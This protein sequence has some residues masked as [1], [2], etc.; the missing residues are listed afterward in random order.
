M[1]TQKVAF[2]VFLACCLIGSTLPLA[3]NTGPGKPA[4]GGRRV[5]VIYNGDVPFDSAIVTSFNG[6]RNL[7]TSVGAYAGTGFNFT[8]EEIAVPE[9]HNAGLT[10]ATGTSY[11]VANASLPITAS[12]Y[13]IVFDL[14]FSNRNYNN[15]SGTAGPRGTNYIRG[16]SIVQADVTAYANYLSTGGGLFILGDNYWDDS[17]MRADGFISRMENMYRLVNQ[18]ASTGVVD[19]TAFKLGAPSILA[20]PNGSNPYNVETDF[21]VLAGNSDTTLYPGPIVGTG[22]GKIWSNLTGLPT[23]GVGVVWDG[24]A[25]DLLPAYSTGRMLYWGDVSNTNAWATGGSAGMRRFMENAIDYLF[26]DNCCTPPATLCGA[27]PDVQEPTDLATVECFMDGTHPYTF[28]AGTGSWVSGGDRNGVGGY[29]RNNIG[30]FS[31]NVLF[32]LPLTAG[33]LALYNQLCFSMRHGL[34]GSI[35]VQIW[36]QSFG[37]QMTTAAAT[38]PSGAGWTDVCLT[39]N[40]FAGSATQLRFRIIYSGG[41]N[42]NY[43]L[44]AISLRHGCGSQPRVVDPACCTLA[45]P[46]FTPT[47]TRT[48]TATHTPTITPTRTPTAT[49]SYSPTQT[50]T[51]TPSAT[52]SQTPTPT[53]TPTVTP[54][55]TMTLT[56]TPSRTASA[57]PTVTP[58]RTE[59]PSH[60]PTNTMGP[61]PTYTATRTDTP[62]AT[63]T[64]TVTLTA[65][66]TVTRTATPT[67]SDTPTVTPTITVTTPFSPTNT[68]TATPSFTASFTPTQSITFTDTAT[69][70]AT[71]SATPSATQTLT[72]TPSRTFSDTPTATLT[73]TPSQTFSATPTATPSRTASA[74]VTVSFTYTVS[75]SI[76]PTPIPVPVRL[77]VVLY[78]SAGERVRLLFDGGARSVPTQVSLSADLLFSGAGSVSLLM[79]SLLADGSNALS[80]GGHNDSGQA[81][82]SGAYYFKLEFQDS[83]GATTSFVKGVQVLA[84]SGKDEVSVYN[85]A[86]EL[87]WA[88]SLTTVA[89]PAVFSLDSGV[90]V[91]DPDPATGQNLQRLGLRFGGVTALQWDGRDRNGLPV[92]SGNYVVQVVSQR[93][94]AGTLVE[95]KSVVVLDAGTQRAELNA[96]AGPNPWKGS[97][98]LVVLYRPYPGSSGVCNLYNLAGERVLGGSDPTASGRIEIAGRERLAGGVYLLEF[99]HQRGS[100]VIRRQ[101]IKVAVV[102]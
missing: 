9:S 29:I 89:Q 34:A 15:G 25:G 100:G 17:V 53:D 4:T 68:P 80:W 85:S 57:T 66:E 54:S 21:N 101:L 99:R 74:T 42:T 20:V 95:S 1:K 36:D 6:L 52:P 31:D 93:A 7:L 71:P 98:P 44:D 16:D 45:S 49:P 24:P 81:V 27:G 79:D 61:S 67:R 77:T 76:T 78:N 50:L 19:D 84:P 94:G 102:K 87:V 28:P 58:S 38:I 26:N 69:R 8:V 22:S 41:V 12:N 63:P 83:F 70:T 18:V 33:D 55:R 13:C 37:N 60:S 30:L 43:D 72:A 92:A 75:P 32:Q 10:Y 2:F 23:H 51:R 86:G 5:L 48:R 11:A 64:A 73:A 62:T 56:A 39:F 90:L 40:A 91:L 47:A 14:R 82:S 46:T 35:N 59:T 3:A 88:A 65:T 97:G 96:V